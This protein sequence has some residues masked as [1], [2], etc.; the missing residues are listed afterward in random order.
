M[1]FWRGN[2]TSTGTV[3]TAYAPRATRSTAIPEGGGGKS[4]MENGDRSENRDRYSARPAAVPG[5]FRLW[6]ERSDEAVY[7]IQPSSKNAVEAHAQ[8]LNN[9]YR[10]FLKD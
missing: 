7:G 2:V 4:E 8:R 1:S 9:I 10:Q 3:F 5:F 6:D